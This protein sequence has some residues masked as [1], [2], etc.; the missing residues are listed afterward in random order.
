MDYNSETVF[1]QSCMDRDEYVLWKGRP[2][3]GNIMSSKDRA[4]L[5]FSLVWLA[6]SLFFESM[7]ITAQAPLPF[8]MFGMVF[9]LIGL[10]LLYVVF[11]QRAFARKK[12]LYVVTNKKLIIKEGNEINIY[13]PTELP[14]MKIEMYKNGNGTIYFSSSAYSRHHGYTYS[15]HCILE[16]LPDVMKAQNALNRMKEESLK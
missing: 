13:Q 6:F 4:M 14:P 1:I 7:I 15:T 11:F 8:I 10:Y 2:G 16:N 9:V 5:P 3:K 12:T